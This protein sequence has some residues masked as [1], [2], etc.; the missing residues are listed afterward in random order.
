ML[1][2]LSEKP[3]IAQK[4]NLYKVGYSIGD[5][6]ERIKNASVEPTYLMS[7]V[8]PVLAV[9]CFNLNVETLEATIHEFFREVNVVFEVRD[10]LGTIYHPREWF[11]APL[12]IIQE[13]NPA[14]S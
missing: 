9:R 2:S 6:T 3:E 12:E 10:N 8:Q 11:V 7:D 14:D 4:K 5:I 13:A 1:R